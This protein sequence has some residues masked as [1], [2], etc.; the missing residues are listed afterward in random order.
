M[1]EFELGWVVAIA[2]G[3]T[4]GAF[5]LDRRIQLLLPDRLELRL[6][7]GLSRV[8][9][10]NLVEG[11]LGNLAS[12]TVT[13]PVMLRQVTCDRCLLGLRVLVHLVEDLLCP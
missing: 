2:D 4:V 11:C 1:I 9:H 5:L 6:D 13:W 10:C 12:A 3:S 7:A 8:L